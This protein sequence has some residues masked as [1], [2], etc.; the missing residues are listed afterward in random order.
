MVIPKNVIIVI[1]TETADLTGN[2][3]DIGWIICDRKGKHL[4][5]HNAL[6]REIM[7]DGDKMMGAF[8]SKKVFSHYVP[9]LDDGRIALDS[10]S[11]IVSI[12]REHIV[13]YG[14]TTIAAYNLG[15]DMRALR[16]TNKALANQPV[17]PSSSFKLLDIWQ[18]ACETKLSSWAYRTTARQLGWVSDAGNIRTGAEYA[19]R[20][21]SDNHGF[22]EDHTALSDCE[23]EVAILAECFR[24]KKK[25]PY[26]KVNMSPWRIPN[27]L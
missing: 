22:I 11:N 18:F 24:S 15:F 8:Y 4:A 2:I 23:I 25:I 27:S 19:Y 7:T 21:C 6:V 26:G 1:D 10:W 17:L 14:V 13:E 12:M 3:Y 16:N 20:F 9:M 5:Q